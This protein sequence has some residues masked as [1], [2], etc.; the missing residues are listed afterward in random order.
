M[1]IQKRKIQFIQE[2]LKYGNSDILSKFEELLKNERQKAL[3]KEIK[4]MA[5]KE[6]EQRIERAFVE[7]K[8]NKVKNAR[9][10]KREI[11]TW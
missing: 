6:Y 8:S 4:P 10:L 9:N 1:D 11:A 3:E 2:F 7:I 5:L